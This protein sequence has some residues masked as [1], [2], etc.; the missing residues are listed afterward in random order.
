[1]HQVT[2]VLGEKL[3]N[4][5]TN[6]DLRYSG[7]RDS[8]RELSDVLEKYEHDFAAVV[9]AAAMESVDQ[10]ERRAAAAE[11][12]IRLVEDASARTLADYM[13]RIT[14]LEAKVG[15]EPA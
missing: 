7:G 8:A 10:A 5:A 2:K 3:L 13:R 11:G 6:R 14:E 15:K 4:W 9:K 1:M 12:R